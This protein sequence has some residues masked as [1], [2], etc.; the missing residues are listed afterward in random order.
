MPSPARK[1]VESRVSTPND[2]GRGA[3]RHVKKH[4]HLSTYKRDR[5][6]PINGLRATR[7]ILDVNAHELDMNLLAFVHSKARESIRR[8]YKLRHRFRIYREY[9]RHFRRQQNW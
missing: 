6:F 2:Y 8:P 5:L 1:Q 7:Q 4:Q 3:R 9:Y